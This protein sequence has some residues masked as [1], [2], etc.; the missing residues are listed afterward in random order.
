MAIK[1]VKG[2]LLK[3]NV[4]IIVHQVNCQGKMGSGLAK[5]IRDRFPEVYKDYVNFCRQ[6]YDGKLLGEALF[7]FD[8]FSNK[9]IVNLFAQD[10]YGYDKKRYT[11]YE[12]MYSCLE[13]FSKIVEDGKSIGIPYNMGCDRG[14]ADWDIVYLMIQ[15]TLGDKNVTIYKLED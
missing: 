7:C 10:K 4:D 2:D 13:T 6:K 8:F 3:S 9:T 14:G 15:K 1:I 5:Q 12:A 11:D